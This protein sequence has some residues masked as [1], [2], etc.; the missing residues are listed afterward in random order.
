MNSTLLNIVI[1]ALAKE[2]LIQKDNVK[3]KQGQID[4][5]KHRNSELEQTLTDIDILIHKLLHND[6]V[7][8]LVKEYGKL[9]S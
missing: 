5:L 8:E 6:N 1:E 9:V 4:E 2:V 3:A 7:R